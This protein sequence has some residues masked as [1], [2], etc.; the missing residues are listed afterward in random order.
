MWSLRGTEI[1]W[2]GRGSSLMPSWLCNTMRKFEKFT[3]RSETS[4]F[5]ANLGLMTVEGYFTVN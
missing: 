5:I 1:G 4:G 2:R 3:E